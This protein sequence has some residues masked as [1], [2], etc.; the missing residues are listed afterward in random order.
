[1]CLRFRFDIPLLCEVFIRSSRDGDVVHWGLIDLLV[2]FEWLM[3]H[4]PLRWS[5]C[6]DY[7]QKL[8]HLSLLNASIRLLYVTIEF[9]NFD[10]PLH[11]FYPTWVLLSVSTTDI[12][13]YWYLTTALLKLTLSNLPSKPFIYTRQ[14]NP[15]PFQF[16]EYWRVSSPISRSLLEVRGWHYQ[17]T[18][19]IVSSR[20]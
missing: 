19:A 5:V 1:M 13:I 20:L 16:L 17:A 15:M 14:R 9:H 18:Q 2:G 6:M 8:E 12:Y 10:T 11:Q 3:S 4:S 7:M